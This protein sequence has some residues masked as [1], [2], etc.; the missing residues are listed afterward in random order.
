MRL[1]QR[2]R[3]P[4]Y[5]PSRTEKLNQ[6]RIDYLH[7]RSA[8]RAEKD[9][10]A[11]KEWNDLA[12]DITRQINEENFRLYGKP[13]ESETVEP[14]IEAGVEPVIEP[15]IEA[16]TVPAPEASASPAPQETVPA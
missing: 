5:D 2:I 12:D 7:A 1:T 11:A 14:V 15:V 9:R 13:A 6:L 8:A 4:Q 10:S 16:Q 3:T